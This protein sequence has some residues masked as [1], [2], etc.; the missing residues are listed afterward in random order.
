[1][2]QSNRRRFLQTTAA[3]VLAAG[4]IPT[5][6]TTETDP[7]TSPASVLEQKPEN[8]GEA[9]AETIV[10]TDEEQS[11]GL[12]HDIPF[13]PEAD[14][15]EDWREFQSDPGNTAH[16]PRTPDIDPDRLEIAWEYEDAAGEPAVSDGTVYY[17][18]MDQVH[19]LDALTGEVVWRSD[20]IGAAGTP[21]I[22]YDTV[23]VAGEQAITA[24]DTS[25]GRIRWQ[26]T[27]TDS[28]STPSV[29]YERVY[30]AGGNCLI[31]LS[32][33]DGTTMWRYR[34]R[35][36]AFGELDPDGVVHSFGQAMVAGGKVVGRAGAILHAV[37]AIT[38]DEDWVTAIEW[39]PRGRLL[40]TD[41][42][43]IHWEASDG[44]AE[45]YDTETGEHLWL[46]HPDEATVWGVDDV[47][48]YWSTRRHLAAASV[49]TGG[50]AWSVE[51]HLESL[52][53]RGIVTDDTVYVA[54][55]MDPPDR[56]WESA[57]L[58]FDKHTGEELWAM[59][60]LAWTAG[61]IILSGDD[62]VPDTIYHRGQARRND[63][64]TTP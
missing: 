50:V 49:E 41:D 45:A 28:V 64:T 29:A 8:T 30:I 61:T 46:R 35:R 36:Q 16:V 21:A 54:V 1:M 37:D 13:L 40:A 27:I 32:V 63:G 23:F 48:I 58:A 56:D 57:L 25:D 55:S 47:H 12:D 11:A 5:A 39:N 60:D 38:G 18:T 2:V 59:D 19:A 26:R 62:T 20:D 22:A 31:A 4:L 51:F 14:A 17:T 52:S 33:A 42:V 15:A 43:V 3:T 24:L 34:S 10:Q 53:R 7:P 6:G 9:D 44:A